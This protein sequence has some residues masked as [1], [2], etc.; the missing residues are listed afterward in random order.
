MSS[1]YCGRPSAGGSV[2]TT[3]GVSVGT[4]TSAGG[5]S[6]G[7][8]GG[9]AVKTAGVGGWGEHEIRRKRNVETRMREGMDCG[10]EVF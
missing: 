5:I 2:G 10:M 1:L 9:V 6:V 4:E 8:D 7:G 3:V